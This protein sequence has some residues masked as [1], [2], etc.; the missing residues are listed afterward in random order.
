MLDMIE[1]HFKDECSTTVEA[2]E[3]EE[4]LEI[5][6]LVKSYLKDPH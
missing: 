4:S 5:G 2:N 1:L 3:K 6:K